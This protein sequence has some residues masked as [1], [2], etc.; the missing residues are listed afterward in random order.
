[1]CVTENVSL[2][3]R[4]EGVSLPVPCGG[5]GTGI[6]FLP[7]ATTWH[8]HPKYPTGWSHIGLI[9]SLGLPTMNCSQAVIHSSSGQPVLLVERPSFLCCLDKV[10]IKTKLL[11]NELVHVLVKCGNEDCDS[12][13]GIYWTLVMYRAQ[14]S[15][16]RIDPIEHLSAWNV[17]IYSLSQLVGSMKKMNF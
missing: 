7:I 11:L 5:D 13:I 12:G 3:L 6:E 8:H 15:G 17:W 10:L 14:I 1:M 16:D 4:T 2:Q 9:C